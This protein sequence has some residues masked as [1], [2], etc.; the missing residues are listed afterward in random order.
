MYFIH[1]VGDWICTW[2]VRVRLTDIIISY[3]CLLLLGDKPKWY[4]NELT[5]F[6]FQVYEPTSTLGAAL[7]MQL[8]EEANLPTGMYL[9]SISREN[10]TKSQKMSLFPA[11]GHVIP[12]HCVILR[13]GT[14]SL[15]RDFEI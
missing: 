11:L 14:V 10:K 4:R 9:H 12:Y 2:N 7:S 1:L 3:H 13:Q 8:E 5:A 15:L 6:T